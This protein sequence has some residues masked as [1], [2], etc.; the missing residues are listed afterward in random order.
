MTLQIQP[1]APSDISDM[2]RIRSL[3]WET[4]EY[5][6]ARIAAYMRGEVD[7]QHAL[8]NRA[9]FVGVTEGHTVGLIAGHLTRR[10]GCEGELEWINVAPECRGRGIASELLRVLAAWFVEHGARRVCVDVSPDNA[11]AR[12]LYSNHGASDLRPHWMAWDDIG[13][14]LQKGG[15]G[16]QRTAPGR[17]PRLR[18]ILTP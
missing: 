3:E 4:P 16:T 8:P 17:A 13:V 18:R 12:R 14:M 10:F 5:W 15:G 7:P 9:L 1:A 2:A 11:P 6:A